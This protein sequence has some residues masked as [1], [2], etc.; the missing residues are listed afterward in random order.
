[1]PQV[2]AGELFQS[3]SMAIGQAQQARLYGNLQQDVA[4]TQGQVQGIADVQQQQQQ[5][6]TRLEQQEEQRQQAQRQQ[7]QQQEQEAEQQERQEL[8]AKMAD[9]RD[10]SLVYPTTPVAAP[11]SPAS[12]DGS[13]QTDILSP[14][15]ISPATTS[16]A[17]EAEEQVPATP[18]GSG[19]GDTAERA[20]LC[21]VEHQSA[22][23]AVE[24]GLE[25]GLSGVAMVEPPMVGQPLPTVFELASSP[26]AITSPAIEV[27][28]LFSA[29]QPAA[30]VL[31][32]VLEPLAAATPIGSGVGDMAERA[33][34]RHAE[35]QSGRAVEP[36]S[37]MVMIG[38]LIT[39][40]GS[41]PIPPPDLQPVPAA[42]QPA[43]DVLEPLAPATPFGS[44]VGDTAE[45]A[46]TCNVEHQSA[47]TVEPSVSGA[48]MIGPLTA[49]S[50]T[51]ALSPPVCTPTL[52]VETPILVVP[53]LAT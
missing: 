39:V 24:L 25:L 19:V 5:R 6:L 23:A 8:D 7:A 21:N 15:N 16:P 50:A 26:P 48:V 51:G 17:I 36:T 14:G 45:R 28:E 33:N 13:S 47:R 1:M 32:Q 35:H 30:D 10:P 18:F 41:G 44:G 43:A 52:H 38:P 49:R 37:S 11:A 4:A 9:L 2:K 31:D 40:T 20:N 27:E 53:Q 42:A 12:S 22:R 46:N 29:A 3:F 34:T